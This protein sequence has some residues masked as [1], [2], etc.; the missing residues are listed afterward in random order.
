MKLS[1]VIPVYNSREYFEDCIKSV[2]NQTFKDLEIICVDDGSTDGT[3]NILKKYESIDNRIKAMY[4]ENAGESAARNRGLDEVTGEYF[5]FVDCDDW[6]EEDMYETLMRLAVEDD[7]DIAAAS[8][9]TEG[10]V[11]KIETNLG[12]VKQGVFGQKDLLKYLYVRD[13]YRGFAYMW[14]KVYKTSVM[15]DENKSILKF[16]E[17]LTLGG[18]VLYLAKLA[19]CAQ[20]IRYVDKP[21]YH[22]RQRGESGC[23]THNLNKLFD[24]IRAYELTISLYSEKGI[25]EEIIQYLKRFMAYHCSETMPD[26]IAQKNNAAVKKLINLMEDNFDTYIKLNHEHPKWIEQYEEHLNSGQKYIF[27]QS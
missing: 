7:L 17:S 6:L 22:Y 13:K 15:R 1:V 19:L 5:T 23:H 18:D 20:K 2:I 21:F 26:A 16:D 3:R 9:F 4:Q 10:N 27:E 24:W 25:S 11:S 12:P 14:N 8:W